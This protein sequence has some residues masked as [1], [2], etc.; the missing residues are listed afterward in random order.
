MLFRS[1]FLYITLAPEKVVLK[2]RYPRRRGG[3]F[4]FKSRKLRQHVAVLNNKPE[5]ATDRCSFALAMSL[6]EKISK[7]LLTFAPREVIFR[8]CRVILYRRPRLA[9]F[10]YF[11][12]PSKA[13]YSLQNRSFLG[14]FGRFRCCSVFSVL[15]PKYGLT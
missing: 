6:F 10:P 8:L 12:S 2:D 1:P 13:V 7:S 15:T 5:S 4:C 9:N 14:C 3:L 11:V